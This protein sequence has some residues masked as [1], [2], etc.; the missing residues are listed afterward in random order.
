MNIYSL[1]RAGDTTKKY[2]L[3]TKNDA[4][5]SVIIVLHSHLLFL[6]SFFFH[7]MTTNNK[8]NLPGTLRARRGEIK[9]VVVG[10]SRT[11]SDRAST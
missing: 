9:T 4:Q 1:R 5:H 3:S 7:T 10:F 6:F 11:E 8:S 2:E